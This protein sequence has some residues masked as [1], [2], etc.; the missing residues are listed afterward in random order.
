M[1]AMGGTDRRVAVGMNIDHNR[2]VNENGFV[3]FAEPPQ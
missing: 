2:T 3:G 1:S